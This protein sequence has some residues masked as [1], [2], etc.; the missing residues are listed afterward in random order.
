[1]SDVA[2]DR[3]SRCGFTFISARLAIISLF[4]EIRTLTG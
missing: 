3:I 4:G 1:M 2:F